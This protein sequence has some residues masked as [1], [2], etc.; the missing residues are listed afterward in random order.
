VHAVRGNNDGDAWAGKLPLRLALALGGV[1]IE[2][3]HDLKDLAVESGAG[4]SQVVISGHS[5]RPSVIE[6]N[7]VLFVNPGSAGRRRFRL[8]VTIGYLTITHGA[9][10][11]RI[12]E[13]VCALPAPV[14]RTNS[15]RSGHP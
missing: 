12:Q 7:G 13:L 8:P 5:H 10:R 2:V 3:L 6:R 9:A 1:R 15:T 11:A 14:M 4:G